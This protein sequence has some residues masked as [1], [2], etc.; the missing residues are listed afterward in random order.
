MNRRGMTLIE[1]L[2]VLLIIGVLANIALPAM[3]LMV[4]KAD[5][6]HVIGDF[7]AIRI[8]VFDFYAAS[9]TY[10]P[11]T[12]WGEVPPQLVTELPQGFVFQYKTVQYRWRRFTLPDGMPTDPSQTVLL[13][14]DVQTS[15]ANLLQ[16]IKNLYRGPLAF[17]STTDVTLVIE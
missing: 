8:A 7:K 4:R 17:G 15:D 12:N 6:T 13:G 3:S 1:L 10:P 9:A 5:A 2:V 11:S 14:L 16:T